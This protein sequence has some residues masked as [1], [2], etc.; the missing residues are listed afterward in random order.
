VV[1]G[2]PERLAGSAA[3]AAIVDVRRIARRRATL[4]TLAKPPLR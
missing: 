2:P 4:K 1:N 3:S